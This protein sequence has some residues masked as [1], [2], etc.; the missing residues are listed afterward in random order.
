MKVDSV[1]EDARRFQDFFQLACVFGRISVFVQQGPPQHGSVG[2]CENSP[3]F[4]LRVK[5]SKGIRPSGTVD[6]HLIS[7]P[8]KN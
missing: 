4:Q 7:G 8:P 3:Q 1:Y 6:F 2:T 5:Q